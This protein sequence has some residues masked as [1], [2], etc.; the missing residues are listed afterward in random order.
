M[1]EG[2]EKKEWED[3]TGWEGDEKEQW[4]A[5]RRGIRQRTRGGDNLNS[6]HAHMKLSINKRTIITTTKKL[7]VVVP[8]CNPRAGVA[9]RDGSLGCTGRPA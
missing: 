2:D 8:T 6:L 4:G 3:S 1:G 5:N 7:G 9:E